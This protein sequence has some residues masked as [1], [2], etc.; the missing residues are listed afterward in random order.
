MLH[1]LLLSSIWLCAKSL[2]TIYYLKYKYLNALWLSL[3]WSKSTCTHFH[4][5]VCLYHMHTYYT[6]S[7]YCIKL[8]AIM[9]FRDMRYLHINKLF[10]ST[11]A[12]KQFVDFHNLFLCVSAWSSIFQLLYESLKTP[13]L[14][15]WHCTTFKW[16]TSYDGEHG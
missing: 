11:C 5:T 15:N 1:N 16:C 6:I 14:A 2:L 8:K 13:Y 12:R 10:M 7:I 3:Y 9:L 4:H